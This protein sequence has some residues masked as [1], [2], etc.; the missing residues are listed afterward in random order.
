M[1]LYLREILCDQ[2]CETQVDKMVIL[3]SRC[4]QHKYR[5]EIG[6]QA[7]DC[8]YLEELSPTKCGVVQ[9]DVQVVVSVNCYLWH[10]CGTNHLCHEPDQHIMT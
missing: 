6:M 3:M 2:Y 4:V 1:L 5:S 9:H 7:Y 8:D 10:V